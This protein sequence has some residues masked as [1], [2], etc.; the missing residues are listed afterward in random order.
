MPFSGQKIVFV[1][2]NLELGGA[3]R[4][5]VLLA[6]HLQVSQGAKVKI[7]GLRETPGQL[8][9][10]CD[11]LGLPWRGFPFSWPKSRP[12]RLW[13]L[14]R[15]ARALREEKPDLL[16]TYTYLPNLVGSLVWRLTGARSMVWNQADEGFWLTKS[17]IN[18]V[19]V[20]LAPCFI[21]N[22]A[23]GRDILQNSFGVR[24]GQVAVIRNGIALPP[25]KMKRSQ[26]RTEFGVAED[27]FVA[28]MLANLSVYKDHVTLIRGWRV[29]VGMV[30]KG[31]PLPLL[32][33]AGRLDENASVLQ[34]LVDQL[35]LGGAVRFLGQVED[36]AGLLRAVDLCVHSSKSEGCP[37]AVLEAMAAGLPV[38]ASDIPG[39]REALGQEGTDGLFP[40]GNAEALAESVSK[41]IRDPDLARSVG[42]RLRQ[43]AEAE[44][45]LDIMCR[46]T[47]EF[48][49]GVCPRQ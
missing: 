49:S 38:V 22:F 33:L 26:W 36:V 25:V 41:Y 27:V 30:P 46:K 37:N 7:C 35:G 18:R 39:I 2:G 6:R 1:F 48:I 28:C 16:I 32:V 45:S 34:E 10:L 20:R 14:I 17:R 15:L 40:V 4:Q 44:F 31:A 19:A 24:D 3:E 47:V 8:S 29:V 12:A 5:G 9:R 43:R 23:A 11:R 21:S 42:S 13:Y